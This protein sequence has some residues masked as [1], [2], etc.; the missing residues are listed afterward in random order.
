MNII[1]RVF[2][3]EKFSR[4]ESYSSTLYCIKKII[5][6]IFNNFR[7]IDFLIT[8]YCISMQA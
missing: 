5:S 2:Y 1:G 7:S 3:I 4:E 6:Y 8:K